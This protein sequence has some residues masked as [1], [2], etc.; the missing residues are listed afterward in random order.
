MECD[1]TNS[2]PA[3]AAPE[4]AKPSRLG[5]GLSALLGETDLDMAAAST[6]PGTLPRELP[7]EFLKPNP[8]QPRKT[9]DEAYMAELSTSIREKGVL[10]PLIVRPLDPSTGSSGVE[11]QVSYEIVAGERRWRAA[12]IASI[13]AVPVVIK[14]LTDGEALEIALVENIQRSD[15]NAIEEA[16]GYRA[17]MDEFGHTQDHLGEI[18]G[19][20]RSHIA[21]ML[22]LLALPEGIQDLVSQGALSAGHGR[23]LLRAENPQELADRIV[24]EHLNVRQAEALARGDQPLKPKSAPPTTALAP[25]DADTL[26]LE[27][28]VSNALGLKVTLQHNGDKGGEVRIAYKTLEQLDEICRRLSRDQ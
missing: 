1:V 3:P 27:N 28:N 8:F 9:F 14:T 5:R 6:G 2:K 15:L 19:K 20:S 16:A 11:E 4:D 13:H 18:V 24:K 21:N 7:V 23:A 10:Q 22:R 12:Q 17:L 25:K 26:A